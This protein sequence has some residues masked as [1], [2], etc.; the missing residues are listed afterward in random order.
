MLLNKSEF[1]VELKE[2]IIEYNIDKNIIVR[3]AI[4][5]ERA[6]TTLKDIL[7]IWINLK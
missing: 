5:I 4:I 7:Q 2:H 1:V 3:Q 6:Q